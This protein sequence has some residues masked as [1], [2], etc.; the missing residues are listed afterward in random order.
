[1]HINILLH[2]W[3]LINDRVNFKDI[4]DAGINYITIPLIWK[5]IEKEFEKWD[6]SFYENLFDLIDTYNFNYILLP[7]SGGRCD[8]DD[9]GNPIPGSKVV[10]DYIIF[11]QF[12]KNNKNELKTY[13]HEIN[14]QNDFYGNRVSSLKYHDDFVL[15]RTKVF[16]SKV[17]DHFSSYLGK[18]RIYGIALGIQQEFEIKYAQNGYKWRD[19]SDDLKVDFEKKYGLKMPIVDISRSIKYM[20]D[21]NQCIGYSKLMEYRENIIIKIISELSRLIKKK[22]LNVVGYFG[23]FF[24]SHD[25]IF[26]LS[27]V[28][29]LSKY[30]DCATLDY[31]FYDG[32]KNDP[33][34]WKI[35][36]MLSY[37]KNLGYDKVFAGFYVER[38]REEVGV[39]GSPINAEIWPVISE[40]ISYCKSLNLIDGLELG[41]FGNLNEDL[42]NIFDKYPFLY[43]SLN[44]KYKNHVENKIKIGI[45]A[46]H[47]TFNWFSGE[48][49]SEGENINIHQQ[50]LEKSFAMFYRD[51]RFHPIVISEKTLKFNPIIFNQLD[52]IYVSHQPALSNKTIE[53][54]SNFKNVLIQDLRMGEFSEEGIYR[55]NWCNDLFGIES[56]E[57]DN[58]EDFD[59]FSTVKNSIDNQYSNALLTPKANCKLFLKKD[60]FVNK[61]LFVRKEN[62]VALGFIP[63]LLKGNIKANKLKSFTLDFFE[64][65]FLENKAKRKIEFWGDF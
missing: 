20:G 25:A 16:Y 6:F 59:I 17:I 49:G 9:L 58:E 3:D 64:Y 39:P 44:S 15:N 19:Y 22:N 26:Q 13:D 41:G 14:F 18:K 43:D 35:P 62:R 65:L 32:Y 46:S 27:V 1:M 51:N 47:E 36:L 28:G 12:N 5:R 2:H 31:N 54:L 37:C 23:E 60:N 21:K 61:G 50:I 57:W 56:I 33:N 29:E 30:I 10:P 38:W 8:F 52:I 24:T 40:S 34:P 48:K 63:C 4:K 55:K 53:L 7:D 42:N 11:S 45:F